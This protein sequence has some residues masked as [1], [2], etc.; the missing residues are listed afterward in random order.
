MYEYLPDPEELGEMRAE[1]YD[2]EN[3]KGDQ[4]RCV[5]CREYK[6][7]SVMSPSSADPYSPPICPECLDG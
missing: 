2:A 4:I 6:N 1:R 7:Y 3:S 5:Q